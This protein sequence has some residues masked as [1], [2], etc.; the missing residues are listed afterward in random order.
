MLNAV[1]FDAVGT[2]I[3]L[4]R[5]V[6]EH[7]CEVARRFGAE[8]NPAAMNGAFKKVLATM[9]D[10]NAG[11]DG[12]RAD[13]DKG[14][15]QDLVGAVL[16][17]CLGEKDKRSF[18]LEGYFEAVYAHFALPGVWGAFDDVQPTLRT[19][20]KAGIPLGVIS[21][22]DRRLY[23]ILKELG[24]RDF[25]TSVTISSEVGAE[26]P[27]PVI[28]RSAL[29]ALQVLGEES[30]HVGDDLHKDGGAVA[31]GMRVFQVSRPS[32]SLQRMLGSVNLPLV[33]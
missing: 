19:L 3:Y 2:L 27:S 7:Y 32:H 31:V 22:F 20:H 21:N 30:L 14:W 23:A 16:H 12:P 29:A 1:F 6:G 18:D 9:P 11:A 25:F 28:F 17:Q 4:P 13:D 33:R 5:S 10:R 26:K 8:L 15:W 24:L